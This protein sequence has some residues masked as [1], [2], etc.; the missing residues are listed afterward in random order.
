MCRCLTHGILDEEEAQ[1]IA[2][3]LKLKKGQPR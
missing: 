2:A 3:E 1:Q